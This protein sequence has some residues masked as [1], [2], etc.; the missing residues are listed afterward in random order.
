MRARLV[1]IPI[2]M[3][4]ALVAGCNTG[5][6]D[7]QATPTPTPSDNGVAALSAEEILNKA[8]TALA[9][10]ESFHVKGTGDDDGSPITVDVRFVGDDF[11]GTIAA[12]GLTTEVI[13]LGQDI[14]L[15]APDD[16]WKRVLPPGQDA[17]LILLR[18][19]YV[20]GPASHPQLSGLA[21]LADTDDMIAPQGTF[22]KGEVKTVAGSPA[23]GL[24]DS[25]GGSVLYISTVG[26]PV[27]LRLEG[28]NNTA[29]DFTEYGLVAP[30][31]AP[32]ATET[33]DISSFLGT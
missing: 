1:L 28:P 32:P 10:A 27:P 23:I 16:F 15:K 2:A 24:V 7:P 5:G 4:A 25:Q 3:A 29:L 14:Y 26:E 19:K 22:T 13:R 21:D 8:K 20:K 18:G 30:I 9:G 33:L 12:E 17:A 11:A 6:G 31:E